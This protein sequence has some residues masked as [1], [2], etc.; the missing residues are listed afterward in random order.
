MERFLD[1]ANICKTA[2]VKVDNRGDMDN[3]PRGEGSFTLGKK[4][5]PERLLAEKFTRQLRLVG[6][7]VP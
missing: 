2:D 5:V 3:E 4:H 6:S 7:A 1:F